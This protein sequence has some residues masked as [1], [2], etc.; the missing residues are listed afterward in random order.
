MLFKVL[1]QLDLRT[2]HIF[3]LKIC[4]ISPLQGW[5]F[6][7]AMVIL[8]NVTT[9]NHEVEQKASSSLFTHLLITMIRVL[10]SV[11]SSFVLQKPQ[12]PNNYIEHVTG[13]MITSR[14]VLKLLLLIL[15]CFYFC[16]CET[17]RR[18]TTR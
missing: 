16:V 8:M 15:C 5:L 7:Y 1:K 3:D 10:G 2:E 12:Y 4:I 9:R 6:R 14:F 13:L 18:V 17:C 11:W